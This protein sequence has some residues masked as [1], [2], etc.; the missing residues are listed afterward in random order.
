MS[1][2]YIVKCADYGN[3]E[4]KLAELLEMMGGIEQFVKPEQR[5]ALKP[6]M[7]LAAEPG[8]AI[9]THPSL[10]AAAGKFF[11]K[12]AGSVILAESPG[13]GYTYDKKSLEKT[14]KMCGMQDIAK[15]A[16]IELSYDTSFETVSFPAGKLVKRFEI[17][18]PI[19]QSDCYI[20]LC[21]L[22]T[23]GLMFMTGGVKNIF[24]VIPGRTKTGYHGT[25]TT[26]ELFAG[27]LLDLAALVPPKLTIMDAV[28]GMEG[29]GPSNGTPRQIGLLI[30]S[31]DPLSLDIVVSEIMGI[32]EE[33]NPLLVEA[34]KRNMHPS[35]ITDVQIIGMPLDQLRIHDFKLPSSFTKQNTRGLISFFGPVAK[36][37]FT[38]DPRIIKS[39]CVAC[40]ACKKACPRDAIEINKVAAIDKKKCIRCY[41]CHEMC[42]YDAIELHQ[43]FLYK[44]VN[45]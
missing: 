39:K 24:G 14:Y 10:V 41:C 30:A 43:S 16:G 17:I 40:G 18:T 27:M 42:Q 4:M 25:M 35:S 37:L 28:V 8:K 6:N 15:N 31:P 22:K 26:A 5:I 20:N 9:T 19:R 7:L 23:H 44:M 11:G 1:K 45:K 33:K 38:V 12:V 3:V 21:K 13:A 29:E 2:V 36:T 34:K 32:P